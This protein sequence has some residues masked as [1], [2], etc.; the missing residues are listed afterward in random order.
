MAAPLLYQR[1]HALC[2][3][4]GAD[5]SVVAQC[6]LMQRKIQTW[7]VWLL[8]NTISVGLFVS[9]GLVIPAALY[10]AFWFNAWYGWWQWS[11]QS[12]LLPPIPA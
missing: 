11:R 8:V 9:R 7:P 6:L 3:F 10:A 1:L 5:L 4:L 2:G 12:H